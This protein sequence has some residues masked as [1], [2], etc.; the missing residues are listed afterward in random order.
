MVKDSEIIEALKKVAAKYGI[1]FAKRLEQ[2]YR[3]E[4]AHWK[5]T[6]FFSTKS[7]GMEISKGAKTFPYGWV[8][9]VPFWGAYPN[10]KPI[11]TFAQIENTSGLAKSK[12]QKTFVVFNTIEAS[13]MS[14]AE[15]IHIR[16]GNFGSWFANDEH[17]KEQA[18]YNKVL[19]TIIPRF[20]NTF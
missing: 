6:N 16:D 17:P 18:A 4:T 8:S 2:L 5:S 9:L 20:C 1:A 14:V 3:N 10:Y 12:G 11:G 15:L 13:M 19:D 7:P